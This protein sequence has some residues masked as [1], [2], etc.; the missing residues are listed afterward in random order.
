MTGQARRWQ[1]PAI[2]AA[3][4]A[5]ALTVAWLGV[6]ESR[7]QVADE[8]VA[9]GG[10]GIAIDIRTPSPDAASTAAARVL[11]GVSRRAE[12]S[13]TPVAPRIVETPSG[14]RATGSRYA[15]PA[16]RRTQPAPKAPF[17]SAQPGRGST[18]VFLGDSFTSG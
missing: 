5:I 16:S 10:P 6:P 15:A 8:P 11:G 12:P 3:A 14:R 18:A 17:A 7:A 9:G 4:I 1:R 2:I 13:T